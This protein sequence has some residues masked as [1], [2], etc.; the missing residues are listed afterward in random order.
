MQLLAHDAHDLRLLEALVLAKPEG[1]VLPYG[2]GVEER[3]ILED[4]THPQAHPVK[5][6]FRHL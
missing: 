4:H 2:H 5:L 6:G 1:D 3:R